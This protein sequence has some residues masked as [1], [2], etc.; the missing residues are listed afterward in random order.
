MRVPAYTSRREEAASASFTWWTASSASSR[1]ACCLAPHAAA[2]WQRGTASTKSW[3]SKF[4][5]F[6]CRCAT[7]GG[8][9]VLRPAQVQHA[10]TT[11]TRSMLT[12]TVHLLMLC[13]RATCCSYGRRSRGWK[14][15]ARTTHCFCGAGLEGKRDGFWGLPQCCS[16]QRQACL[17]PASHR[18]RSSLCA[19]VF[20]LVGIFVLHVG[21]CVC[22]CQ[23][24][25]L[26]SLPPVCLMVTGN[27]CLSQTFS[28]TAGR[29]W[30]ETPSPSCGPTCRQ[31]GK[32]LSLYCGGELCL[33]MLARCPRPAFSSRLLLG[34]RLDG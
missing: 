12:R 30:R 18:R 28:G 22:V 33:H 13:R 19:P 20:A 15:N 29:S 24:V 5:T 17:R 32:V 14:C 21:H 23:H 16:D 34:I 31:V 26:L 4:S 10:C 3:C 25:S 7:L 6:S 8:L 11:A 1:C 2:S 27:C 9:H